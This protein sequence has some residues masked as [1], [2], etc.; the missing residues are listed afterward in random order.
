MVGSDQS[1][2]K[3]VLRIFA[4][5]KTQPSM[6]RPS[7]T[8]FTRI[9]GL[10]DYPEIRS[11]FQDIK[12]MRSFKGGEIWPD[13]K[14]RKYLD[15]FEKEGPRSKYI[16]WRISLNNQTVGVVGIQ[17]TL[18]WMGNKY[19]G[20]L[21]LSILINSNFWGKGYGKHGVLMGIQRFQVLFPGEPLLFALVNTSNFRAHKLMQSCGFKI[22]QRLN[23]KGQD[24]LVI[25]KFALVNK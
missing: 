10:A 23:L 5:L 16:D 14:I 12:S 15:Y 22:D 2:Q 4:S 21:M 13:D 11:L 19:K 17:P 1:I 25:Y 7:E 3:I 9:S 18:T 24:K 6:N 20:K 8:K